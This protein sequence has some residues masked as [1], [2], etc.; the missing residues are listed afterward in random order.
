MSALPH[1]Q[2]TD[3]QEWSDNMDYMIIEFPSHV[4]VYILL[5]ELWW[6]VVR[7]QQVLLYSSVNGNIAYIAVQLQHNDRFSKCMFLYWLYKLY[8]SGQLEEV[9]KFNGCSYTICREMVL[10]WHCLTNNVLCSTAIDCCSVFRHKL[11]DTERSV[12]SN[13]VRMGERNIGHSSGFCLQT[14]SCNQPSPTVQVSVYTQLRVTNCH[15]TF[16]SLSTHSFM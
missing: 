8:C 10:Q 16:K 13:T 9:H 5:G 6:N 14:A 3:K 15:Q 4:N 12:T 7:T 2:M 11:L 1:R